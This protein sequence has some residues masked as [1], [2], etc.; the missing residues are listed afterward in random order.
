[1]ETTISLAASPASR[2]TVRR[3]SK[4]R[5]SNKKSVAFPI[6]ARKLFSRLIWFSSLVRAF[7]SVSL[8]VW[9]IF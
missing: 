7:C 3:Q 9:A 1:M 5:G 8:I 2:A 4:P 6:C